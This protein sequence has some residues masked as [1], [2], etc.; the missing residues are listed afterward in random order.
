MSVHNK[1]RPFVCG[2]CGKGFAVKERLRLHVRIHTGEKPFA[3]DDCPK[4]FARNGQLV[5]H[6]RSH[7]GQRPYKCNL[8]N[9]KFTS[10]GNLKVICLNQGA[11][12]WNFIGFRE[13]EEYLMAYDHRQIQPQVK[14]CGTVNVEFCSREEMG[15]CW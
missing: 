8:C 10:S 9:S 1:N 4:T 13:L 7:T 15:V 5:Q 14:G 3:C 11:H 2:D 12:K 6:K